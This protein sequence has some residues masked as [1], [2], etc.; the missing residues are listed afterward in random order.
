MT[1]TRCNL[2]V[3]LN[4]PADLLS[5]IMSQHYVKAKS[6]NSFKYERNTLTISLNQPFPTKVL[7]CDNNNNNNNGF[8]FHSER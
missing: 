3:L 4:L 6:T 7:R 8:Y 2:L 1:F 5:L